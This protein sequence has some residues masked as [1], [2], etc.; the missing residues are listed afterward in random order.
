MEGQQVGRA[1]DGGVGMLFEGQ[2]DVEAQTVIQ[3]GTFVSRGHD[4]TTSAGNNHHVRMRQRGT[5]FAG[6]AIQRMFY[7]GAGRAEHRDFAPT[8]ELFQHPKGLLQFAQGLQCDL[9]IPAVVVFL[10]HA[11][12]GQDHVAVDRDV[13]A[14]G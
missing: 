3:A 12:H 4:A 7:R 5:E 2:G 11:Q 14:V 1:L 13:R 8:L 10:G 6:E 9:G